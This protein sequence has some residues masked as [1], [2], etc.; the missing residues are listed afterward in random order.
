MKYFKST[1]FDRVFTIFIHFHH[2]LWDEVSTPSHPSQSSESMMNMFIITPEVKFLEE[3]L[4][5]LGEVF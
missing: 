1:T 5:E 2:P 3:P 4:Q